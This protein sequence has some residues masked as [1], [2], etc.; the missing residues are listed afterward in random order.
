MLHFANSWFLREIKK[1]N[2]PNKHQPFLISS[3]LQL[4]LF[5]LNYLSIKTYFNI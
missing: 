2:P 3:L 4:L 5:R 1:Q